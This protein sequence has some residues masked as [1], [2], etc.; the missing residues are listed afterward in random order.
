[1]DCRNLNVV[2]V[3]RRH[4]DRRI[5][6]QTVCD[7]EDGSRGTQED[8]SHG[9]SASGEGSGVILIC[10]YITIPASPAALPTHC[11]LH[12]DNIIN[13]QQRNRQTVAVVWLVLLVAQPGNSSGVVKDLQSLQDSAGFFLG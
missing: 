9:R 1:M 4:R 6:T 3:G 11:K 5:C 12:S 2:S 8:P 10:A 7:E 13:Q